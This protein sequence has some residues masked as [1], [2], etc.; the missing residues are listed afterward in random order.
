MKPKFI[1]FLLPLVFSTVNG[2]FAQLTKKVIS[3]KVVSFEDSFPLEGVSI[4]VK[5]KQNST[6]TM[7]DGIYQI[8]IDVSDSILIF[9]FPGYEKQEIKITR[10]NSYDVVL[11]RKEN[12]T[13]GQTCIPELRLK[14]LTIIPPA[15]IQNKKAV[16]PA[17]C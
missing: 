8:Q 7:A 9:S 3:G 1:L 4:Q 15:V 17:C 10:A 5:G 13:A 6:G 12:S 16:K 11:K 2:T 14:Q